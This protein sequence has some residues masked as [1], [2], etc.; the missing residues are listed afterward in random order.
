MLG[1]V[2][3]Y[4]GPGSTAETDK[5]SLCVAG[6]LSRASLDGESSFFAAAVT[7]RPGVRTGR[8][9]E[10]RV[11]VLEGT[12]DDRDG[13]PLD[14]D[15]RC[16]QGLRSGPQ[17]TGRLT[18]HRPRADVRAPAQRFA[19]HSHLCI[20]GVAR[21]FRG[22]LVARALKTTT[23]YDVKERANKGNGKVRY[24]VRS[25]L[26]GQTGP[27]SSRS[28]RRCGDAGTLARS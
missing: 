23:V 22:G 3:Q 12:T 6:I 16:L 9:I 17:D 20:R 2:L 27:P 5:F 21:H 18:S 11:R 1:Q 8:A 10:P 19:A 26:L 14:D 25:R 7:P 24:I 13:T 28:F 15:R 4:F